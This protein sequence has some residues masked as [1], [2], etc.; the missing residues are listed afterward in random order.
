MQQQGKGSA[1]RHLNVLTDNTCIRKR[2][3]RVFSSH[4]PGGAVK[5]AEK[6][7]MES[8]TLTLFHSK[9][10][11]LKGLFSRFP[12]Y[13]PIPL[14]QAVSRLQWT[15]FLQKLFVALIVHFGVRLAGSNATFPCG[16]ILRQPAWW[17]STPYPYPLLWCAKTPTVSQSG[18]T[19]LLS[20]MVKLCPSSSG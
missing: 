16:R 19:S 1:P 12:L 13:H 15:R 11:I 10:V 17:P 8:S 18:Q 14:T 9:L 20:D 3:R 6:R 4:Q 5:F 2:T 7:P